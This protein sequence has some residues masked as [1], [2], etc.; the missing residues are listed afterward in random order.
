MTQRGADENS[1]PNAS[2]GRGLPKV[3]EEETLDN[4]ESG[5]LLGVRGYFVATVIRIL[6]EGDRKPPFLLIALCCVI[7]FCLLVVPFKCITQHP[8]TIQLPQ[9]LKE[10]GPKLHLFRDGTVDTLPMQVTPLLELYESQERLGSSRAVLQSLE[11]IASM[12]VIA[13]PGETWA[14]WL[15]DG[16]LS[17]AAWVPFLVV[18]LGLVPSVILAGLMIF[19]GRFHSRRTVLIALWCGLVTGTSSLRTAVFASVARWRVQLCMNK[20]YM[21]LLVRGHWFAVFCL[22]LC[23][24]GLNNW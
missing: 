7:H 10:D 17:M 21:L 2:L 18:S 13:P 15:Y 8:A 24:T 16:W 6:L 14:A 3:V 23:P 19:D 12:K 20:N 4:M 9:T 1:P 22:P 5:Q 11:R